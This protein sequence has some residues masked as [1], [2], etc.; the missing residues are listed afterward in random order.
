MKPATTLGLLLAPALGLWLLPP[1]TVSVGPADSAPGKAGSPADAA[2]HIRRIEGG[3]PGVRLG[4][5]EPPLELPLREVMASLKVTGLSVAVV[6]NF[7]VAWAKGYG[8]T[9]A[10]G[11]APVTPRT[12]FQ[13]GSVSKPVAAAGA[14]AL[15]GQGRLRLD[16]DV[17]AALK[18]WKVR[19]NEFTRDQKVTLR[20]ILSH[21]AGLTV[22]GFNGYEAGGPVPPLVQ[23]LN[24][25]KPAN[26]PAVVV[27]AVPGGKW[28]Y[29][30][31]G[32]LVAQQ[33]MIDACGKPFPALMR[34]LVFD[35]LGMRD[36]SYEQPLPPARAAQAASGTLADGKSVPG[37]WHV[38]PEMA[39]C[40]LWTTPSDLAALAIEVA[41]ARHGQS[42]RVL[43]RALAAEMLKPQ[44]ALSD[45]R[46]P[47]AMGLGWF[48]WGPEPR[49]LFG[50]DGDDAGFRAM[51]LMRADSGR[52]VAVMANS[53]NGL[54]VANYL[55]ERV[56]GE[57]GWDDLL[58]PDRPRAGATLVLGAV[59]RA[60]GT[61]AAVAAYRELKK[62]RSPGYVPGPDTLNSLVYWLHGEAKLS[63]ALRVAKLAAE[64]YPRHWNAFDTLGEM[65]MHAGD[66]PKAVENYER[67]IALNPQNEN[68][69]RMRDRLK[70]PAGEKGGGRGGAK[71]YVC[72]PCGLDC[73]RLTF[74]KPG[75]CPHCGMTLVEKTDRQRATVGIL[76]F[77]GVQI[78]D[79][80]GPWEVFGQAGF[81][82]HTV[83]P[84]AGPVKTAFGQRVLP[85]Y[86]LENSPG[87]D[88]LLIPGGR[89]SD[90]LLADEKLIRW[91]Q[92]RSRSARHVMSVCTGAFLL[93]KAGLLD[94]QTATT[95]HG[96]LDGLARAA[97]RAKVV[98]DRR[99]VDN[100]KVI[101]TAGLTSGMDGALHL[102]A[103]I[104]GN[105]EAQAT[106]LGLEYRWD[107]DS[108]YARAALA[109]RY[110]PR[111]KGL[112]A[113]TLLT[114]GDTDRW[115]ARWL[116]PATD[117]AAGIVDRMGRQLASAAPP[118]A[119][120]VTVL[121]GR[122]EATD[123][124]AE[125]RWTFRDEQGRRWRGVGV[126]EAS[127]EEKGRF[128]VTL[129][130]A[131]E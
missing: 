73:D 50:H 70:A 97:P 24:G 90:E 113:K 38:Y 104:S 31:G 88:I 108:R 3:S 12:M 60:K 80:S 105:G 65:Y 98:H 129:R 41:R 69:I 48:L 25:E 26:T 110:L 37:R 47:G 87:A 63:D 61:E 39:A 6:D 85:D 111:F 32:Y 116:V 14:L 126:A 8:V 11:S 72:P 59:A 58:P 112:K 92:E 64:E 121:P 49:E 15:V 127:T 86:T 124:R 28:S 101:T 93:A 114:Q 75:V 44:A 96:S 102:V 107:P 51:L 52:A 16:E 21:T 5:N 71:V 120:E 34:E 7:E 2:E 79:Y 82:V 123:G 84:K 22:H 46:P 17:N 125:L 18:T 1:A 67:S 4:E 117:S 76:L 89:V 27:S 100:G 81:E 128:V 9:E 74:D 33:M 68:G 78:I 55:A 103:K 40:G 109:D 122:A 43:P 23:V 29:S 36:S 106:A 119:S 115:E 130:L 56:A 99:F 83:A 95:F 42:D 30:G 13:A 57:Y 54:V 20:R 62:G 53:D 77:D 91:I 35:R 131:R 118:R 19:E 45:Q 10:G 94:G 66:K